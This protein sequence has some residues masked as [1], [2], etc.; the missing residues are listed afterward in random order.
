MVALGARG[1]RSAHLL[2]VDVVFTM[3]K[4]MTW[5]RS[6]DPRPLMVRP[7]FVIPASFAL[8][9]VAGL[10]AERLAPENVADFVTVCVVWIA[11]YPIPRLK[12]R[13][14]WWNHWLQG[15]VVLFAFWLMTRG[16]R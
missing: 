15:V 16:S 9:G 5:Q 2:A 7:M 8:A 1:V 13:I 10:A 12:P 6:E 4:S 3:A 11:L 14:P